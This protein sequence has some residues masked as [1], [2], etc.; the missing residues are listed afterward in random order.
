MITVLMLSL[1]SLSCSSYQDKLVKGNTDF[2]F[3]N[4]QEKFFSINSPEGNDNLVAPYLSN[5]N[6]LVTRDVYKEKSGS[7]LHI[8]SSAH[9]RTQSIL[10]DNY[11]FFS[12]G[13]VGAVKSEKEP[14]DE[15]NIFSW[16]NIFSALGVI[17]ALFNF[18]YT[19]FR[20][21]KAERKSY[22]DDYWLRQVLFPV[23][24]DLMKDITNNSRKALHDCDCQFEIFYAGYLLEKLNEIS[25]NS[26]LLLSSDVGFPSFMNEQIEL[27]EEQLTTASEEDGVLLGDVLLDTISNF[28]NVVFARLNKIQ[29]DNT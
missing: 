3:E 15:Q 19:K 20:D 17:G 9:E 21:D 12:N 16:Q 27:I 26:I 7:E 18:A 23:I 6:F 28:V 11:L 22:R 24:I 2:T 10:I 5:N 4:E 1:L 8:T 25:D 14:S 29:A 13:N